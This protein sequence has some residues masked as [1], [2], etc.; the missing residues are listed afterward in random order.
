M[1]L[2][3]AQWPWSPTAGQVCP[4]P[5]QAI[6]SAQPQGPAHYPFPSP[7]PQALADSAQAVNGPLWLPCA[8]TLP[9]TT[10][11]QLHCAGGPGSWQPILFLPEHQPQVHWGQPW[12][13]HTFPCIQTCLCL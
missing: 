13:Q 10:S 3:L 6:P 7:A 8:S 9:C 2:P 1:S 4:A 11:T 12:S 5:S